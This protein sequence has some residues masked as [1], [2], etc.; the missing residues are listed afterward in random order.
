MEGGRARIMTALIHPRLLAMMAPTFY[1]SSCTIQQATETPDALGQPI[2]TWA[3]VA[4]LTNLPCAVAPFGGSTEAS[5]RN[6]PDSTIDA[7]TH[8]IAIAGYYPAIA[9]KMRAIVAG[10]AYDIVGAEIDSHAAMT[11]LRVVL[12][13]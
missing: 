3:N 2:A 9:S 11:R 12:V 5:Q 10:V 13:K 8:A 6:R 4:A 1:V 7:A